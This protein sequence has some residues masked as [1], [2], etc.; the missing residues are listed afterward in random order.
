MG[1]AGSYVV[2]MCCFLVRWVLG[3]IVCCSCVV[4]L[5]GDVGALCSVVG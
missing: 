2:L 3:G 5:W 1:F 4:L